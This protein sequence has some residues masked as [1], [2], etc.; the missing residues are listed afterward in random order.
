MIASVG[1]PSP[2]VDTSCLQP[3]AKMLTLVSKWVELSS[4]FLYATP[5]RRD[6]IQTKFPLLRSHSE[7]P[8]VNNSLQL[9]IAGITQWCVLAPLVGASA[10]VQDNQKAKGPKSTPEDYTKKGRDYQEQLSHLHAEVLSALHSVSHTSS[11]SSSNFAPLTHDAMVAIVAAL[12][13]FSQEQEVDKGK[14][15]QSVERLT[16]FLQIAM[17]SQVLQLKP[18]KD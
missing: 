5:H 4:D 15:E 9:P 6:A 11:S 13:S 14:M 16:Q 2:G 10:T 18:G 1:T 3:P 12:L 7:E 17:T 8:C